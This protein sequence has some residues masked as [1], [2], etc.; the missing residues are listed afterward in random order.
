L[1]PKER[2]WLTERMEQEEKYRQERHGADLFG[3]FVDRRIWLLIGVYFTVAVGSNAAGSYF[4]QL[5]SHSF[6]GRGK[7]EIGLLAALPH[8]AAIVGMTLVGTHSDRTGE[9]RGHVAFS[10]F[11][12]A[13]GWTLSVFASDSWLWLAGLCLAQLG[14]MSMLPPFWA[15]PTSF[16]SGAAAAG[17]IALINSVANL[18]GL[19]GP[20]ILGYFG[21]GAMAITLCAGGILALCARHDPTLDRYLPVAGQP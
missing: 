2:A 11:L 7:F 20:S 6:A 3:A 1:N 18:G 4:P 12:A 15:L 14:M 21:L 16:L 8:V 5:I 9:R 17:G 13:A 19:L 10:A